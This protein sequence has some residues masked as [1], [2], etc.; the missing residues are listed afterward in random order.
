MISDNDNALESAEKD[1]KYMEY[2]L[3]SV[4]KQITDYEISNIDAYMI[5]NINLGIESSILGVSLKKA[6]ESIERMSNTLHP[7]SGKVKKGGK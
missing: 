6:S 3:K 5:D 1:F 7:L 2:H 4:G